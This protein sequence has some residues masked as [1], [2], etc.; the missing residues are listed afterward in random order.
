[1]LT[2]ETAKPF[3]FVHVSLPGGRILKLAYMQES[4]GA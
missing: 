1:M 4:G 3:L 2:Q